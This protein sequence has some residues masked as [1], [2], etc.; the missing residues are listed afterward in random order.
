MRTGGAPLFVD[1]DILLEAHVAVRRAVGKRVLG[2]HEA[3]A[4]R[5]VGAGGGAV[6]R[7]LVL[8]LAAEES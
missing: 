8:G 2:A 7:H 4:L 6:D 1:L 3:E 5:Q